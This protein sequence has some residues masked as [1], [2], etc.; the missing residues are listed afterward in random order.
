MEIKLKVQNLSFSYKTEKKIL[1]NIN[2]EV[3]QGEILSILGPNGVGKT[4]LLKSIM[5]MQKFDNG[6]CTLDDVQ[7]KN[8]K[9]KEL[10]QKISYVP[11]A[12][13]TAFSYLAEEMVLLGRS[14][15]LGMFSNPGKK[16]IKIAHMAMDKVGI[17]H[18][19]DK[20]CNQMSGGEMQMV[21]IARAIASEPKL[22]ILDEPES[23]LDFKNQLI[24]LDTIKYLSEVLNI[25]CIFNTHYPTHAMKI[26]THSLILNR[27][28]SSSFGEVKEVITEENLKKSFGV[29]VNISKIKIGEKIYPTITPISIA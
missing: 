8:I 3:E 27:D 19:K 13:N 14:A 10:W 4:T 9:E 15:Y 22:L 26:S 17:L 11:Q 2:F 23:N 28:L 25:S 20:Y 7:I 12:K 29:D 5:N 24:V 1:E 16:D 21:L 6:K 18:L